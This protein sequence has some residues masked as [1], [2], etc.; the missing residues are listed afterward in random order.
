VDRE[1]AA[2]PRLRIEQTSRRPE[3]A[4]GRWVVSW[5]L[6]NLAERPLRMLA[7]RL[8]HGQFRCAPRDVP[9]MPL[10]LSD[11]TTLELPVACREAPGTVI[12]NAFLILRVLHGAVPW[13]VLA[14]FRVAF[15][16]E[17]G[18]LSTT[19]AVTVHPVGFSE[20][21]HGDADE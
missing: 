15:D 21:S 6:T 7:A 3:G 18:P 20:R 19:E 11:S 13:R 2:G 8:P 17:G 9:A 16:A 4:S 12:E 14:R 5:R 10:S 1:P